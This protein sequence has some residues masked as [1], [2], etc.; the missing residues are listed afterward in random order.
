[1]NRPTSEITNPLVEEYSEQH[2]S[3]EDDVLYAINR[4]VHLNTSNPRM[5]SGPYQGRFLQII[6]QICRPKVAVEVGVFAGYASICI[7]RGLA[8]NGVLH[9]IEIDDEFEPLIQKHLEQAKVMDKVQLHIGDAK[10]VIPTLED[11]IDLVYLDADKISYREYYEMLLPKMRRGGVMLV[12]NIL[13]NGKVLFE[14][15]VGDKETKVLQQ[16]ND[17]IQSDSRVENI[18]LPIRDG[19]MMVRKL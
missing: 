14:Q 6:S 8:E 5:S 13:W 16:L 2:T 18:L 11:E 19:L 15:P 10:E 17:F 4:S 3:V 12:D 9:A 1:M 7:A